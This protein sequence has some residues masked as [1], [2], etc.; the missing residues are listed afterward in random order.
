MGNI[1]GLC[2]YF[3]EKEAGEKGAWLLEQVHLL[4]LIWYVY[5]I[6]FQSF[7]GSQKIPRGGQENIFCCEQ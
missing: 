3:F 7:E 2:N 4:G 5:L 6:Y 1:E